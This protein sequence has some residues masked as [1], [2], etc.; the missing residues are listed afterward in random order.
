M[1]E[2]DLRD[3]EECAADMRPEAREFVELCVRHVRQARA[4]M[5]AALADL[6]GA[7]RRERL[8]REREAREKK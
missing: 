6:R 1:D 2:S 7:L 3:I 8:N 5:E 4:E